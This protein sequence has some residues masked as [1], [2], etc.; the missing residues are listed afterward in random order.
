MPLFNRAFL[1]ISSDTVGTD[2]GVFEIYHEMEPD[3]RVEKQYLVGNAGSSI[4]G[5]VRFVTGA[6]DE[7]PS[8]DDDDALRRGLDVDGGGGQHGGTLTFTTGLEDVRWGD[9]SGGTGP[10]NVTQTDASGDDVHPRT[11]LDVLQYW[12]ANTL[13]DSR[14][15]ARLHIGEHT[16]G[17][18]GGVSAGVYGNA[19]P[20]AIINSETRRP[21]EDPSDTEVTLE[22]RKTQVPKNGLLSEVSDWIAS[23]TDPEFLSGSGTEVPDA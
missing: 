22:Y 5:A 3:D 4:S 19:F 15:Q 8:P 18:Y 20:V 16:D 6:V 12:I 23:V 10:N 21:V 13:T 11:R 7:L 14:G 17:S 1:V 9:G 2:D